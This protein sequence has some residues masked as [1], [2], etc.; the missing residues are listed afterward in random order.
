M[1]QACRP[2]SS[3]SAAPPSPASSISPGALRRSA[4]SSSA[5]PRCRAADGQIGPGSTS[6]QLAVLV[7]QPR[8]PGVRRHRR[9]PPRSRCAATVTDRPWPWAGPFR[10]RITACSATPPLLTGI[11]LNHQ[12]C[13]GPRAE[14]NATPQPSPVS[15]SPPRPLRPH[16]LLR[17]PPHPGCRPAHPQPQLLTGRPQERCPAAQVFP[18]G[19][20]TGRG[21]S[22]RSTG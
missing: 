6:D 7:L 15:R 13:S 8:Q 20:A 19:T 18:P 21:R 4:T 1:C 5:I 17:A 16:P 14:Y 9:R 2:A 12:N 3:T 10:I 22:G 11:T